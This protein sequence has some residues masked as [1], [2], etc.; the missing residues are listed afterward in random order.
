MAAI[1][2]EVAGKAPQRQSGTEGV[3]HV[4]AG[5]AGCERT[6]RSK[7]LRQER[8]SYG[9]GI[10][11]WPLWQGRGGKGRE[12]TGQVQFNGELCQTLEGERG[13][14]EGFEQRKDMMEYY[15]KM[16]ALE[17]GVCLDHGHCLSQDHPRTSA[18]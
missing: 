3:S 5:E 15:F 13:P 11:G 9:P 7:M 18:L 10:A 16:N 4:M 12:C 1:F 2:R 8:F 14:L 17:S 6:A